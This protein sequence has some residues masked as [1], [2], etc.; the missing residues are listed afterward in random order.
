[1]RAR[2]VVALLGEAQLLAEAVKN[3]SHRV[4]LRVLLVVVR[5]PG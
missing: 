2:A 5:A 1:M 4:L 3:I